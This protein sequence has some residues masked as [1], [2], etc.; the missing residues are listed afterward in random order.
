MPCGSPRTLGAFADGAVL[1]V[2]S[3]VPVLSAIVL[4][5]RLAY[6]DVALWEILISL[7]PKVVAAVLLVWLGAQI[8][9]RNLM[10]TGR[11]IGF[12]EALRRGE[13]HSSVVDVPVRNNPSQFTDGPMAPS[14]A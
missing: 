1:D 7:G 6:D 5:V 10:H 14:L 3:Q 2:A 8:Y 4:P 12:R 9:D 11:K 13:D